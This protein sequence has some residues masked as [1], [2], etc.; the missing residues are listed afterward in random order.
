MI[1]TERYNQ[2]KAK[3]EHHQTEANKAQGALEQLMAQLE[4]EYGYSTIK[5][6]KAGLAERQVKLTEA[7]EAYN[8]AL[9]DFEEEW[10]DQLDDSAA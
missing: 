10:G 5:E 2:L 3:V 4:K 9:K 1:D 6:A 7:E 8:T